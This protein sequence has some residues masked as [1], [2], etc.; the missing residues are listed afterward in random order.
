M[1]RLGLLLLAVLLMLAV[2]P[3]V[4]ATGQPQNFVAQLSGDEEVPPVDTN[5]RGIA[6]FQLSPDG[7]SIRFRLAVANLF[8]LNMAHIHCGAAGTNGPVVV[9]LHV[10]ETQ[11][12]ELLAG[13][14][15]GIL[16]Q[17]TLTADDVVALPDSEACP[18]GVADFDDLVD[19]ISSELA[20]VN[21]HTLQHPGGE[22]RGQIR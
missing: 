12:P 16:A 9:W 19:K 11:A 7:E 8:D 5:A 1:K 17:G 15:S 20:Y 21:V 10:Q 22:I 14:T 18:G 4:A 13:R 2:L 3:A 6:R